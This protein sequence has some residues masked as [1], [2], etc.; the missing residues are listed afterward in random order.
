LREAPHEHA[1]LEVHEA[2]RCLVKG[3]LI[4]STVTALLSVGS[5]AIVDGQAGVIDLTGVTASDSSGLALLVEWLSVARRADR[6]LRYENMPPQLQQLARLS[7]VEDLFDI[8]HGTAPAP[9]AAAPA[10]SAPAPVASS[11]HL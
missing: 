6:P 5:A 2:Q 9:A 10:P 4:F 3:P 7:E 1:L 11:G 8:A